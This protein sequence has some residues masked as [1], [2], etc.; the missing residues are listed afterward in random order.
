MGMDN[1]KFRGDDRWSKTLEIR[2]RNISGRPIYG[3]S[4]SLFFEHYEPRMAF[5]IK[6][7]R[8]PNRDLKQH[9]IQ[10]GE[11]IELQIPEPSFNQTTTKIT[12]FGLSPRELVIVLAVRSALF[13]D[14]FGWFGGSYLRRDPHN[15]SNWDAMPSP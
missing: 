1:V 11:E 4:A 5:E 7:K 9:P 8:I 15:G 3:V 6:L 12:Q 10:A 13:S 14:D 2:L